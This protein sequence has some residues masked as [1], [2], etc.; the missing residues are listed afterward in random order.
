[1][2]V[3]MLRLTNLDCLKLSTLVLGLILFGATPES[4]NATTITFNGEYTGTFTGAIVGGPSPFILSSSGIGTDPT[5]AYNLTNVSFSHNTSIPDFSGPPFLVQTIYNGALTLSGGGNGI[6]GSYTGTFQLFNDTSGGTIHADLTD[7]IGSGV[8]AGYTGFGT[9]DGTVA[10][11]PILPP[12]GFD[13][14]FD[15]TVSATLSNPLP[16]ALPLFASGLGAL[17]LLGWHRKRKSVAAT[18]AA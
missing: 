3:D 9:V 14:T 13:G 10:F 12:N 18:A 6:G 1:M 11:S 15:V 2:E 17:G 4:A 7:L 5:A 8:L 16:A